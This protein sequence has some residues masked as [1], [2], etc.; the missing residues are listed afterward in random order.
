MILFKF[1]FV[2]IFM[3]TL[4]YEPVT[5]NDWFPGIPGARSI[6][7]RDCV[8]PWCP[9]PEYCDNGGDGSRSPPNQGRCIYFFNYRDY[10]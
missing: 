8:C 7:T 5:E 9:D 2:A 4:A 1:I 10:S 3:N 6:K